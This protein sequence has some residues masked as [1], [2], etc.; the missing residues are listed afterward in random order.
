MLLNG[1][2]F[3][4][5]VTTGNGIGDSGHYS[6]QTTHAPCACPRCGEKY[7][8]PDT[9]PCTCQNLMI[10]VPPGEHIHIDCP[11]HGDVKI[12]GPSSTW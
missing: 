1:V 5:T 9:R 12:Y 10:Y 2:P 7:N 4:P 6:F 11:R 8:K 3:A